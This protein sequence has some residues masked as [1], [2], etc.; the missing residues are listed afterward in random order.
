MTS[1]A[2][3]IISPFLTN[4]GVCLLFVEPILNAF[5]GLMD[6]SDDEFEP[7]AP[8]EKSEYSRDAADQPTSATLEQ[9][10]NPAVNLT[11]EDAI[12]FMLT[13]ACS[14]NIGSSLTYTGNP[15]VNPILDVDHAINRPNRI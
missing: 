1:I 15:Q 7:S 4:D 14:S 2:S 9:T 6:Q 13:L 11:K 12:Y 8:P 5:E 3:L 10:P